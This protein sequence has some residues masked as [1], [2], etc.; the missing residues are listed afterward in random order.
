MN[1]NN[2]Y[3]G[4]KEDNR[5]LRVHQELYTNGKKKD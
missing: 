5:I 2:K 3:V 4:G 1:C